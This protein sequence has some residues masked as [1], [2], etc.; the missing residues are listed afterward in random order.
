MTFEDSRWMKVAIRLARRGLGR[1]A[2]NPTV[3]CLLV[4]NGLVV[5]RGW[6]QPGGRPHAEAVALYQAGREASGSTAY[7]TLEPCSHHGETPPCANALIDAGV[8]RVVAAC[9]DPDVRVDGRGFQVL[10]DANIS[11]TEGVEKEAAQAVNIGFLSS[12]QLERPTITLKL[13]TTIDSKISLSNGKSKWITD[14]NSRRFVH[15]LR[16]QNDAV[17]TGVGTVLA[18]NPF[19]NCRLSGLRN[20]SPSRVVFDSQ[21]KTPVDSNLVVSANE[22]KTTILA[23]QNCSRKNL[24]QLKSKGVQIFKIDG[25]DQG[26]VSLVPA[27]RK[28]AHEGI[29]RI[30]LE[31]GGQLAASFLRQDLVDHIFWFRAPIVIG[32]DGISSIGVLGISELR[33]VLK[34]KRSDIRKMGDD[35][36]EIY[37]RGLKLG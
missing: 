28:L 17:A 18:D 23:V 27:L 6:T 37:S 24:K 5:G 29:T 9:R 15:L 22:Q 12:R 36:L 14:S 13:A 30:L 20:R 19:L 3:G 21:L 8:S 32:G 33:N 10:R 26:R 16:A 2:P 35:I 11:V 4:K 25:E 31:S 1:T 34:F 7:V